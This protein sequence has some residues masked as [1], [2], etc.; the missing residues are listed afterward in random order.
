[1]GVIV[2]YA[3]RIGEPRR[4]PPTSSTWDY[5]GFGKKAGTAAAPDETLNLKFE[6]IPGGRGGY[7]RPSTK[8]RGRDEAVVHRDERQTISAHHEQQ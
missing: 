8:S 1:M 5:T 4:M 2:E 6:K 3:N 7:N